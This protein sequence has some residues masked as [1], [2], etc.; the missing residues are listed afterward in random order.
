MANENPRMLANI[1]FYMESHTGLVREVNEDRLCIEAWPDTEACLIAV[2][3]GMGGQN[4]GD[5]AADLVLETLRG[6]TSRPLPTIPADRYELL[7]ETLYAA[8]SRIHRHA[9]AD[10]NLK[11]MGAAAVIAL[12]TTVECMHLSVGDCRLYRFQ[13]SSLQ[14]QTVDQ[15]IPATL[16]EAGQITLE[17]AAIHPLRSVLTSALGGTREGSFSAYPKWIEDETDQPTVLPIAEGDTFLLCSDGLTSMVSDEQINAFVRKYPSQP[18]GLG[19]ACIKAA[20]DAGGRDNVS[21]IVFQVVVPEHAA[22][23]SV[24]SASNAEHLEEP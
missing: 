5:V 7:L 20:L 11:G 3:D 6:I 4:A 21:V 10:F 9:Q 23:P 17:Q 15:T 22:S 8:D 24:E 14:Y 1:A 19:K 13:G 16:L 18:E 12:V 2:V